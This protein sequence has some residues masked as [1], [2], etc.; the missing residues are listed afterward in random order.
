MRRALVVLVAA[1][2]AIT[3]ACGGRT[4]P[5]ASVVPVKLE[6]E[7]DCGLTELVV[8]FW[9]QGHAKIAALGV[10]ALGTPHAEV[11]AYAG[12]KTY[13]TVNQ[14]A[15]VD[16]A[17]KSTLARRCSRVSKTRSFTTPAARTIRTKAA[18]TCRVNSPA[19]VRLTTTTGSSGRGEVLLVDP[20]GRIA[21]RATLAAKGSTLSFSSAQ[22][23]GGRAPG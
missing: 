23:R 9:P 20:P 10:R 5:S 18:V 15:Y 16:A 2:A 12:A 6:Q 11:Y 21:L 14:V 7:G 17:G 8:L 19:H 13:R 3:A 22:C 4:E 1:C